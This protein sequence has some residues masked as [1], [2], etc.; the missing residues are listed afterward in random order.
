VEK[1]NELI[2]SAAYLMICPTCLVHGW[3]ISADGKKSRGFASKESAKIELER[4]FSAG[5]YSLEERQHLKVEIE[6]CSLADLE[7]EVG[8]FN[9][10][11]DVS[12]NSSVDLSVFTRILAALSNEEVNPAIYTDKE[13]ASLPTGSK[14]A[15]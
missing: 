8:Y 7:I 2:R 3:F 15:M 1:K 9:H 14:Y 5:V 4:G 13:L 11:L 10:V 12:E 6:S